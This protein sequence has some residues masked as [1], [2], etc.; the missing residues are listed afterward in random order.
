MVVY[1]KRT[2]VQKKKGLL[3]YLFLNIIYLKKKKYGELSHNEPFSSK[4]S[5]LFANIVHMYVTPLIML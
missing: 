4:E 3:D 5:V 2:G 1:L